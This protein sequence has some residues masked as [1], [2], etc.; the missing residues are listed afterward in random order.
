MFPEC[1]GAGQTV[2]CREIVAWKAHDKLHKG[3]VTGVAVNTAGAGFAGAL[4]IVSGQTEDVMRAATMI[5]KLR[6]F[7]LPGS[8]P[9]PVGRV[10]LSS[11]ISGLA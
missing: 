8:V 6:R 4:I 9:K 7:K 5:A 3:T 11:L 1:D 10:A 2:R